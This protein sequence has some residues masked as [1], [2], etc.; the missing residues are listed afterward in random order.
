MLQTFATQKRSISPTIIMIPHVS[1]KNIIPL[2]FPNGVKINA[3]RV[4]HFTHQCEREVK[5]NF[6]G[7]FNAHLVTTDINNSHC[8]IY[9]LVTRNEEDQSYQCSCYNHRKH[10]ECCHVDAVVAYEA[11]SVPAIEET[12]PNNETTTMLVENNVVLDPTV[13]STAEQWY[14]IAKQDRARQRAFAKDY[15]DKA[16]ALR[17]A[18]IA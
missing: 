2:S 13:K 8:N 5:L 3:L 18:A 12:A 6:Q 16:K 15:R 17:E 11:S 9:Y 7:P 10:G 4:N 1:D 14:E